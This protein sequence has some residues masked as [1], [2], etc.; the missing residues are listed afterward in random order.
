MLVDPGNKK[1][2]CVRKRMEIL[3][4]EVRGRSDDEWSFFYPIWE[5]HQKILQE[6]RYTFQT[7]HLR[8]QANTIRWPFEMQKKPTLLV[9]FFT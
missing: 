6:R 4:L 7:R 9:K 1:G 3:E 2:V 5:P 8:H